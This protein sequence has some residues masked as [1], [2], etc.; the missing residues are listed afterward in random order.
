MVVMV[1][2]RSISSRKQSA[3]WLVRRAGIEVEAAADRTLPDHAICSP[4]AG[5]S[6]A[7][8]GI[9]GIS[10]RRQSVARALFVEKG[11]RCTMRPQQMDLLHVC[12]SE[13]AVVRAQQQLHSILSSALALALAICRSRLLAAVRAARVRRQGIELGLQSQQLEVMEACKHA[14]S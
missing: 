6:A 3:L 13:K 14:V 7:Q 12:V 10:P 1:P 9:S 5:V 2:S 11:R 4:V 8:V